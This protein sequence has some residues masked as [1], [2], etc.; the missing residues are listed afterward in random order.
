MASKKLT[1]VVTCTDRKLGTPSTALMARNLPTAPISE[2]V[3]IW[4]DRVELAKPT[5]RLVDLYKGEGW[6]Q[7]KRLADTAVQTGFDV[8]FLVASAG[9][10]LRSINDMGPTYAATFARG[11]LDTV[12]T[13]TSDTTLWW[14]QLPHSTAPNPAVPSVWVLSESY[15]IAMRD[16]LANLDQSNTLV[17]GGA[18]TTPESIRVRS[19][20]NLRSALG[21]TV[22]SLN[23]RSAIRWLEIANGSDLT[24]T[25]V[26]QSW[27]VWARDVHHS[28]TYNRRPLPDAAIR[29]LIKQMRKQQPKLSKTVALRNLRESGIACEQHRFSRLFEEADA[30]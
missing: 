25:N 17:F 19:D 16:Q 28:E 21:G 26:R 30:R 11:H 29:P 1:I 14:N 10:G 27:S 8:E 9:L 20:R 15:A 12:A 23:T 7:A 6:T 22:T 18:S 24:A 5:T 3:R 2:R 13:T 4:N